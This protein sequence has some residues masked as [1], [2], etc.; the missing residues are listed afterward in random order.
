MTDS[1]ATVDLQE[2]RDREDRRWELELEER[3]K[4]SDRIT[5][6]ELA[7][8]NNERAA[9]AAAAVHAHGERMEQVLSMGANERSRDHLA[10]YAP[11]TSTPHMPQATPPAQVNLPG[12]TPLGSL[13]AGNEDV[14]SVQAAPVLIP[15]AA[16]TP[17]GSLASS[18]GS[19]SEPGQAAPVQVGMPVRTRL[20]FLVPAQ[21]DME[22]IVA[23]YKS[24]SPRASPGPVL[25]KRRRE[26]GG[27]LR[28]GEPDGRAHE[29]TRV[30]T[31]KRMRILEGGGDNG[32]LWVPQHRQDRVTG[33]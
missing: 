31:P 24:A 9:A 32:G 11:A 18:V 4:D 2:Q 29:V 33:A 25:G 16:R 19:L 22:A 14:P 26:S 13:P 15:E 17:L 7:R 20:G 30:S 23:A 3:R 1:A 5:Q 8:L 6:L 10:H 28:E 21:I 27:A 12:Q